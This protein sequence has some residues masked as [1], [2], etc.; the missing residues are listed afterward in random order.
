M[1][2]QP[3]QY[4]IGNIVFGRDTQIPI[5]K[6]E[7]Q[8]YNVNNQD[9]QVQRS[10]ENR[11][12]IDT[13]SPGTIVFSMS[14]LNNFYLDSMTPYSD[15]PQA[16]DLF[17]SNNIILNMLAREWKDPAL[18]LTWGA[19]KPITFCDKSGKLVRIYGRPGKFTHS[20]RNKDG[21]LWIDVQAEFR[22]SD[23]YAHGD[24]EYYIGH[25]TDPNLGLPPDGTHSPAQRLDGD[26]DSWLRFLIQGPAV[27]P[28][29]TY[30]DNVIQTNSNIPAG[31][32]AEISSY[33]WSRRYI[34]SNDINRRTEII[35][36]TLYLDQ[37]KFY[38]SQSLDVSWT[39]TGQDV[40]TNLLFLW[41]EAYN[42]I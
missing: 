20:P 18:R 22:R 32:V 7:I 26:G 14:V 42:V 10:D 5:Q 31:V 8:T 13:L 2:L 29:I 1:T 39:C 3:Y 35:G 34:D 23:T 16:D 15:A 24:I 33:P 40:D 9:F 36:D 25:P 12:G 38:T 37:I 41:R 17:A 4:Q 21:E 19:T 27:N 28:I 30:G 11:F 6:V